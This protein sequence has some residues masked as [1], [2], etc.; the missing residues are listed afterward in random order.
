[1]HE[2]ELILATGALLAAGLLASLVAGRLRIPGLVLFLGVGMAIGSD[3]TGWIE[4]SNY[5]LARFVGIIALGLI[6]YEGGLTAGFDEIRPV[7]APALSLALVGTAITAAVT[8]VAAALL[9]DLSLLEGLLL[10]AI[11]CSTDGAAI[12]AL[13][14]G[15]TLRRRLA[16]TLEGEAGMNDPVA[17]LLVLGFVEWIMQPEGGLANMLVLL[18]QQ[19]LIGG[20]VGLFV[21]RVA[22]MAFQRAQLASAGLYPVASIATAAIAFGGAEILHGS[23]FLSVYLA[24]LVIGSAPIPAKQTV[25]IFHQGLAWVA[26]ITLFIVLGLLVFPHELPA[27]AL[28]GLLITLVLVFVA[29]PVA[30]A[31]ATVALGYTLPERVALSWAGL[32]G[33]VPVVLATFPVIE[34]IQVAPEFFN[35]VFFAVLISTLL[36]GATFEPL[37]RRL[38][39]TT[40]DPALPRPLTETGTIRGLGAE[41]VEYPVG[42]EDAIVGRRVRELGLPRDAVINVIVRGDEA[43]P[44]RG[45][46]RVEAGDALHVLI[47]QEVTR[48][49]G[50]LLERW[51]HGPMGEPPPRPRLRASSVS[52]TVRPWNDEDGDPAHPR[53]IGGHEVL[54]HVRTRRDRRGALV[55]LDDGRLAVTG[56]LVAVGT[57]IALQTFA[58][59][60]LAQSSDDAERGWWQEVVGSIATPWPHS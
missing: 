57:P 25:T 15:S 60:R 59:R 47:R 37:S 27:V 19:L 30:V 54:E 53:M 48:E 44:P 39:V 33:A 9:L 16:R 49:V 34:G 21:G 14:R 50:P 41:V 1:V 22:A 42:D 3:G 40:S 38:G 56:P 51:R 55:V 52:F 10:G 17:V 29:R 28:E 43:I 23:A 24:G 20:A 13:L 26:Q 5:E 31:V 32:R 2:A 46:T 7:L 6:L 4:F 36:Q 8:G 11:L 45:S 12:F 18:V 35:I 58:R